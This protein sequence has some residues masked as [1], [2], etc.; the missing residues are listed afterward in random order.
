[1]LPLYTTTKKVNHKIKDQNEYEQPVS[2][3]G[4]WTNSGVSGVLIL[5]SHF[6][7]DKRYHNIVGS[8]D[9]EEHLAQGTDILCGMINEIQKKFPTWTKEQQLKGR[10]LSALKHF[11]HI[12][13]K[14]DNAVKLSTSE[15]KTHPTPSVHFIEVLNNI[16]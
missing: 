13:V 14:R 10:V 5:P 16:P 3:E 11:T 2:D 7:V 8:W 1:M 15:N 9:S 12:K 6:Q 4:L